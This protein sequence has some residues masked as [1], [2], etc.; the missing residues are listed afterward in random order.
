MI[1]TFLIADNPDIMDNDPWT[2]I[3]NAVAFAVRATVHTT[4]QATPMQLVFGRDAIL[5][6]QMEANWKRIKERK[7]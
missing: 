5:N 7:R 2:G 4:T 1:R 6:I 3:L